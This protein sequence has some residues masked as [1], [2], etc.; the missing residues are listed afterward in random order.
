MPP[1]ILED[2]HGKGR[3]ETTVSCRSLG[4]GSWCKLAYWEQGLRVGR[5]FPVWEDQVGIYSDPTPGL[6]GLC[7]PRLP[8]RSRSRAVRRT[9]ATLGRGLLL[10]RQA[11][12]VWAHNRGQRPLFLHSPTLGP[13]VHKVPAGHAIKAFDYEEEEDENGDGGKRA[14]KGPAEGPGPCDLHA[15]RISFAKGWGPRYSR[16]FITSCPCWVEVLLNAPR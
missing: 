6:G 1:N 15:L 9:R 7:L 5:L 11:G 13:H 3:Q 14:G 12:G 4:E 2:N 10:S 8:S 16:R